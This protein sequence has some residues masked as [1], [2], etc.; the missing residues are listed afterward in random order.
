MLNEH[1]ETHLGLWQ[2]GFE[3]PYH[4]FLYP[5]GGGQPTGLA[6]GRL[7]IMGRY[8]DELRTDNDTLQ[9]PFGGFF[10]LSFDRSRRAAVRWILDRAYREESDSDPIDWH[11]AENYAILACGPSGH[12]ASR[13][14][15]AE[16]L[17][18]LH[19]RDGRTALWFPFRERSVTFEQLS[20]ATF[21]HV[22]DEEVDEDHENRRGRMHR[23]AAMADESLDPETQDNRLA[24]WLDVLFTQSEEVFA[25]FREAHAQIDDWHR[26]PGTLLLEDRDSDDESDDGEMLD[27][28]DDGVLLDSDQDVEMADGDEDDGDSLTQPSVD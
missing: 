28:S 9:C 1:A 23:L 6:W 12:S 20:G 15:G 19:G 7:L 10:D 22:S 5:A 26:R 13:M 8:L 11:R 4:E 3:M 16:I 14:I 24:S 17:A 2:S 27:E 18:S 21:V 25:Q